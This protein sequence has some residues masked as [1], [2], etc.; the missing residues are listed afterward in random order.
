MGVYASVYCYYIQ[1][2]KTNYGSPTRIYIT[3]FS[4][5]ANNSLSFRMLFTNPDIQDVFPRFTFKAFG[6][7]FSSPKMMGSELKGIFSIVD[8]YE[9]YS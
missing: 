2:S 1:G 3:D 7:S 5:P 8:P 9:I 4:I 6:G